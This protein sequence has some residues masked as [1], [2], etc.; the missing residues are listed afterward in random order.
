MI[1]KESQ[2]CIVEPE[3]NKKL[4][5]K[6]SGQS[7]CKLNSIIIDIIDHS[8][9]RE[10]ADSNYSCRTTNGLIGLTN[11][12]NGKLLES[13]QRH[14]REHSPV[15]S[16]AISAVT[17]EGQENLCH[18]SV[19]KE[20]N[21][22]FSSQCSAVTSQI[23][24]DLSIDQNPE[25]IGSFSDS[26]SEIEDLSNAAKYNIYYNRTSFSELLEM[27][28]STMLREVNSERSKSAECGQST[29][30]KHDKLVENLEKSNVT[31][32]SLEASL[33]NEY[34]LK[35]TPNLGILEVNCY[36]PLKINV[37]S[38][39]SSKDKEENN[40]S[41]FPTESDSQATIA[42]S[43]GM[44]SHIHLNIHLQQQSNHMQHNVFHISGQT[45]DPLQKARALDFG[46]HNY[47]MG[48]ENSKIDSAPVKLKR[49]ER[50]KEKKNNFNWDSL[51][52]QAQAKAG[53]REKTDNTMDS[54]AWDAVRCADVN[55][56]ADAIK[57]RGMNN[58]LAERIKV[59]SNIHEIMSWKKI[60]FQHTLC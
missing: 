52:I 27:A 41:S 8:E 45:Q 54:L 30:M 21:D 24:G 56:I 38:S 2:V 35:M 19:R 44:L 18:G 33:T 59:E 15:E 26:N 51:R 7:V 22:V 31:Q 58:M 28:S 48:N 36:D 12:S 42:H 43:Q 1:V 9:E 55:E 10:A 29:D 5:E 50:G 34:T 60:T 39:G 47:A 3:E 23:S 57:E 37:P 4:D 16:G 13:S 25:K 49:R 20:L 53:K 6:I 17:G 14:S 46:D 40:R 11:E 32:S